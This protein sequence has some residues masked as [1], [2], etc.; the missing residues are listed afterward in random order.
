M[1]EALGLC[2]G[3]KIGDIFGDVAFDKGKDHQVADER[4]EGSDE[5]DDKGREQGSELA[6]SDHGRGGSEY[7]GE[8]KPR[9]EGV[10]GI[11]MAIRCH[12]AVEQLALGE[13]A[14]HEYACGDYAEIDEYP[15]AAR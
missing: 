13:K 3:Q 6:Q 9:Y 14:R 4:A 2:L 8:E 12:K 10:E 7:R 5:G 11:D 1:L 15:F